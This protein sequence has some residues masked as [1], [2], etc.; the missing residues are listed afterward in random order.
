MTR[1][2][3]GKERSRWLSVVRLKFWGTDRRLGGLV[4]VSDKY[5]MM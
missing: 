2:G 4:R 1:S 5:E 3:N